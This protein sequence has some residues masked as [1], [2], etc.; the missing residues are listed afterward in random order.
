MVRTGFVFLL[1]G[2]FT[3]FFCSISLADVPHLINY[4]GKLATSTGGC[5]NDTL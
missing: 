3:I 4:Q 2:A 5:L 1:T